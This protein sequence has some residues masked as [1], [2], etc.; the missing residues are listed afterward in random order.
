[1]AKWINEDYWPHGWGLRIDGVVHPKIEI[2]GTG[3][4]LPHKTVVCPERMCERM[5]ITQVSDTVQN[6]AV[7]SSRE[8]RADQGGTRS[9]FSLPA[10]LETAEFQ[11]SFCRFLILLP[12]AAGYTQAANELALVH[13]RSFQTC[14]E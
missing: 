6:R 10:G 2:T 7:I 11:R 5:A 9:G 8:T 3:H 12:T 14:V 4:D 13:D 1:M